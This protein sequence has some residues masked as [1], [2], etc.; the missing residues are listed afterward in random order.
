MNKMIFDRNK[1]HLAEVKYFDIKHNGIEL[2][3]PA[4]L[5]IIYGEEG[6]YIN[7]LCHYEEFPTFKRTNIPNYNGSTDEYFGTK[8][9]QLTEE[10]STGPCWL[11][12]DRSDLEE[13]LE[14]VYG[15]CDGL[16]ETAVNSLVRHEGV[17]IG[18][19]AKVRLLT[20]EDVDKWLAWKDAEEQELLYRKIFF[21]GN[22]CHKPSDCPLICEDC[23]DNYLE[24]KDMVVET[25]RVHIYGEIDKTVFFTKEK[26]EQALAKME[27]ENENNRYNYS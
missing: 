25:N 8:V 18:T 9:V 15:E 3:D 20:D 6:Q 5:V 10:C 22:Y 24:V 16:L 23:S 11:I 12:R 13:K 21:I 4:A 1:L 26:A 2:T 14:K 17:E 19:P 7:P 27:K